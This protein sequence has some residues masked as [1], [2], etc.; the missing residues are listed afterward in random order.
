MRPKHL[1][2]WN[3]L[4]LE[5][6]LSNYE[7]A[8]AVILPIPYES[9]VSYGAGT[10]NGPQAIIAASR[11]VETYDQEFG[12]APCNMGIATLGE[13][14]QVASGPDAMMK[15]IEEAAAGILADGKFLMTLGGEHSISPPLV[16][17]HKAL[18]PNLSVLQFD[19]HTDLR[20]EYQGSK[21]SH[22]CAMSRIWETCGFVGVGVR[23]FCGSENENRAL[24]EGRLIQAVDFH[25]N[26]DI[27]PNIL[28]LLADDVYITFDLDGLDPSVIPAVGTPEPGGLFW[29]E[30]MDLIRKVS[31]QRR[32]VGADVVELAPIPGMTYPDFAAARLAYKIMTYALWK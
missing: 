22:A 11:Q 17:A 25:K 2:P 6:T 23:N 29:D 5:D 9:T 30:T 27:V 8:K 1:Y 13:L 3:F 18:Y 19:A 31:R 21:Y 14:E 20:P 7:T 28:S 32:I 10:R 16:R 24:L 12:A 26:V 15:Q 4:A